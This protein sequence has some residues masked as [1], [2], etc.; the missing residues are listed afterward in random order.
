[1]TP[2]TLAALRVLG[3][4]VVD[5]DPHATGWTLAL[6]WTSRATTTLGPAE[7]AA[8]RRLAVALSV[9]DLDGADRAAQW[10]LDPQ[11]AERSAERARRDGALLDA[12][13]LA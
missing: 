9:G 5:G 6:D 3:A 8:V 7:R 1:M 11:A 12:E 10:V 13:V 4:V 2:R